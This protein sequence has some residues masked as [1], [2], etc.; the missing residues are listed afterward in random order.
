MA[1]VDE[2]FVTP[3]LKKVLADD[4]SPT[5][6]EKADALGYLNELIDEWNGETLTLFQ[7]LQEQFT[8]TTA[9]TYTIGTGG[10]FN[11]TRPETL[12]SAFFR[13]TNGVIDYPLVIIRAKSEWDRI[14]QKTLGGF[15]SHLWYD[16]AYPLGVVNIWRQNAGLLFLTSMKQLTE[17]VAL[18][19]TVALPPG[20]RAALRWNLIKRL[21]SAFNQPPD[22][23]VEELATFSLGKIRRFNQRNEQPV[24]ES[25]LLSNNLGSYDINRGY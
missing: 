14:G 3:A 16:N 8:L 4:A 13:E 5:A 17:F 19:T 9:T 1:T 7:E 6:S 11:T 25:A 2:L 12:V 18:T 15:P 22:Q 20:Y 10:A 24:N 21:L 23:T